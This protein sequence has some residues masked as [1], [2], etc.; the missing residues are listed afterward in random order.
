[1]ATGLCKKAEQSLLDQHRQVM[2][3]WL[4]LRNIRTF[5]Q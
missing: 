2:G 1:M 3:S 5:H 4:R